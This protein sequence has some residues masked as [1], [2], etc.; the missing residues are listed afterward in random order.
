MN[1]EGEIRPTYHSFSQAI[2][3]LVLALKFNCSSSFRSISKTIALLNIYLNLNLKTPTH[4]TILIWAKKVGIYSLNKEK[5]NADDW[6][7]MIDESVEFG[8]DKLLLILGVRE[9]NID[10]SKPLNYQNMVCLKLVASNTWTGEQI[11]EVIHELTLEIGKIK[12]AVADMGNAI[13]KALKLALIPHVHDI[14]HKLSWFIKELL[15]N[16]TDFDAYCKKLAHLRGSMSLSKLSYILPPQQRVNSRFMNLKPIFDWGLSILKLIDDGKLNPMEKEKL[17]GVKA[18]EKL[19]RQ[20]VEL[21]QIANQIQKT[22]KNFGLS[23]TTKKDCLTLFA[24]THDSRTLQFKDMIDTY[25]TQTIQSVK[26]TDHILSSSDIL[27]S[28][29]G[30]YKT[31]IS[32][33]KSVGITDL[34]LTIPAFCGEFEKVTI[35]KALESVK[36]KHIKQWS[37]KNLSESLTMKRRAALN[38]GGRKKSVNP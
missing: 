33:N 36:T 4:V 7:I 5:E 23:E 11:K 6:I 31:Y 30:K 27:E 17:M 21:I 16:D 13:K 1:K 35:I 26:D 15:K 29:F 2:I 18:H 28:S 37:T 9:A 14:N 32:N 25:F 20:L 8:N 34:S 24:N 38:M 10:F 3:I 12:Y 22:I 19:I